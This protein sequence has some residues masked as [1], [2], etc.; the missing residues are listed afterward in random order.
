MANDTYSFGAPLHI[1]A[2]QMRQYI[3]HTPR[4]ALP[5]LGIGIRAFFNLFVRRTA[6]A[7]PQKND[8][9]SF[10]APKD[11]RIVQASSLRVG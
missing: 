6:S 3:R 8:R 2:Y 10:E 11:S 4:A 7:I 5:V 1:A 9:L